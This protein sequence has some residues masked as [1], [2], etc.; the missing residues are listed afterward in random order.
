MKKISM[1]KSRILLKG[2]REYDVKRSTGDAIQQ[3]L[4]NADQHLFIRITE[5]GITVNSTEIV[6][7]KNTMGFEFI[8]EAEQLMSPETKKALDSKR[9]AI[10]LELKAKG[11]I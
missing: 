2:K 1:P 10:A 7:I 8:E 9:E 3:Q 6:E 4:A 5:L 11:I